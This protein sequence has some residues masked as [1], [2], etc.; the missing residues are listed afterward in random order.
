MKRRMAVAA[1][2]CAILPA[3]LLAGQDNPANVLRMSLADAKKGVDARSVLVV[4][5]RDA[6]SYANGHIPGAILI[7]LSDVVR[8]AG[9][10]RA[11]NKSIVACCA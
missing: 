4:D 6:V 2:V 1:V 9:E 8:R 11:A 7:P 10:L 5:V 3:T